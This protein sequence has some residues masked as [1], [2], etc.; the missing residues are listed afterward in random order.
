MFLCNTPPQPGALILRWHQLRTSG[1]ES[2]NRKNNQQKDHK[3]EFPSRR[4]LYL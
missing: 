3:P 1:K 4:I 2:N